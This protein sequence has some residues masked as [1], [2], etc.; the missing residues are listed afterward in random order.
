MFVQ[1]EEPPEEGALVRGS[2]PWELVFEPEAGN[3]SEILVGKTT[4]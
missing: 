3:E 1:H 4:R 2:K